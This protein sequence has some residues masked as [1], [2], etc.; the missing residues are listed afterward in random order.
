MRH[1]WTPIFRDILTSSVWADDS[2]TRIVWFTLLLLADPEGY[3]PCAIPGLAIAAHVPL[4]AVRLAVEKFLAP[5]RD[6][7]SE[8]HE[9]R[10]LERVERGYRILNFEAHAKRAQQEAEKARK[11]AWARTHRAAA[12]DTELEPGEPPT[13]TPAP[14][15]VVVAAR[16]ETVDASKSKSKSKSS[17]GEDPEPAPSR[18]AG[19]GQGMPATFHTLDGWELSAELRDEALMAGLPDIDERIV[20]ARTITIGGQH[21]VTSQDAWV[22][23]Q[24]PRW[25]RWRETDAAKGTRVRGPAPPPEGPKRPRVK[26]L[27][28]WVTEEHAAII[29]GVPELDL[30]R[31]AQ[32]F[33]KGHHINVANLRPVDLIE[34]FRK[35]LERAASAH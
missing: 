12:N 23:A 24:F 17:Q 5:D 15:E 14:F 30:R 20:A 13:A 3:V 18:F 26:G 21:G 28:P 10:R 35:H 22:R 8:G 27:P 2:D 11:R 34:P 29:R 19:A 33:A 31:E 4:E 1:Y 32:S 25:R 6:S 7:R 9:G 16:S